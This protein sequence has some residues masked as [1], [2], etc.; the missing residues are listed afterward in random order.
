M[1]GVNGRVDPCRGIPPRC[2]KEGVD[3]LGKERSVVVWKV[4]GYVPSLAANF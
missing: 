2:R 3:S 1:K 4:A